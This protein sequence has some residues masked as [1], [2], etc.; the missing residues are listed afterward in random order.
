MKQVHKCKF[1]DGKEYAVAVLRRHV[2]EEALSSL[3]ALSNAEDVAIVAKRLGRLVFGEF[4]L[5]S[6]GEALEE[7]STTPIGMHDRFNVVRVHHHSPK[8]L[9]EEVARGD[10]ISKALKNCGKDWREKHM[11][12]PDI[13]KIMDLLTEYH[14]AVFMAFIKDGLIHSDIHLGNAVVQI[15]EDEVR[16]ALFDVGQFERIGPA[17]TKAILWSLSWLS[18]KARHTELRNVALDH[19]CRTSVLRNVDEDLDSKETRRMLEDRILKAFRGAVSP[20]EDGTLPDKKQAFFRFLRNSEHLGVCL[21][22]GAFAVAK[23]LDGILSQEISFALPSVVDDSIEKFLR[24]GMTWGET[25]SIVGVKLFGGGADGI[26]VNTPPIVGVEVDSGSD[27]GV[28][29]GEDVGG[30]GDSPPSSPAQ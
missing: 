12:N 27:S 24:R 3:D 14:R 25:L 21:P 9:V 7:F 28:V 4:N 8:C 26:V 29:G 13:K 30:G 22:K 6:E 2:E 19:L 20:F 17:D 23:M 1:D 10:T 11:N 16:F 15:D 5:F 18:T